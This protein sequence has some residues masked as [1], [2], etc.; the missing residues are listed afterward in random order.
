MR[1]YE[2]YHKILSLWD[3]G[4]Y[5]KSELSRVVG[6]PRNTIRDVIKKFGSVSG[7]EAEKMRNVEIAGESALLKLLKGAHDSENLHEAYAYTLGIYLGDGYISQSKGHRVYRLRVSLDKAYPQIVARCQNSIQILLPENQVSAVDRGGHFDVSCYYKYWPDVLPQH[8]D[9]VKHERKIELE[10]WQ[11]YIVD[12][13]P[14]EFFRGLY[15]SDGSRSQNIVKGKNYPRYLFCSF[16]SDIRQ[17]YIN[18]VEKLGLRWT[19]A[20]KRNIAISKREDVEWLD[21]RIGA[22]A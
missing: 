20:N 1:T 19:T 4:L 8:G 22:K 5:N 3:T 18:V 15:H 21:E 17:I 11:Q 2:E 7:L 16:S 6:I 14:L 12:Q 9:G 10:D 13:Y